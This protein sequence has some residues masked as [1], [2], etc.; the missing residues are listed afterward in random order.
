[1]SIIVIFGGILLLWFLG[2]WWFDETKFLKLLPDST[3]EQVALDSSEA[4]SFLS[5]Y[6]T[7]ETLVMQD[8]NAAVQEC[9]QVTLDYR[10]NMTEVCFSDEYGYICRDKGPGAMLTARLDVS[11]DLKTIT[12]GQMWLLCIDRAGKHP[13]SWTVKGNITENLGPERPDCWDT[14]APPRPSDPELIEM[15]Q[16]TSEVRAYLGRYAD[17]RILFDNSNLYEETISFTP[18][19]SEPVLFLVYFDKVNWVINRMAVRCSNGVYFDSS[20][21]PDFSKYLETEH[22]CLAS[23]HGK[24]EAASHRTEVKEFLAKYPKVE[25]LSEGYPYPDPSKIQYISTGIIEPGCTYCYPKEARLT[26]VFEKDRLVNLEIACYISDAEYPE[27]PKDVRGEQ[28]QQLNVTNFLQ[29]DL[30]P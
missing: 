14:G 9:C 20:D 23:V 13:G 28:G 15:A 4:K 21:E 30:C 11:P 26:V 3:L 2:I 6:P 24:L 5:R 1:M 27:K 17:N 18:E 7:A 16:N 19:I 25:G 8:F 10:L 22:S 12:I 29:S